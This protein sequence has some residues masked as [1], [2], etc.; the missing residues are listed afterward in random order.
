MLRLAIVLMISG[1]NS[2]VV[3]VDDYCN[4]E[5][6]YHF[7][8]ATKHVMMLDEKRIIDAHNRKYEEFCVDTD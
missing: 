6:E 3:V 4:I 7:S 1:C 2:H 8:E 5:R